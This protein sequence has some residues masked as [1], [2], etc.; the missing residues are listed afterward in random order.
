MTD[1]AIALRLMLLSLILYA[2]F[3]QG[4]G[5]NQGS[6]FA[7][8]HAVATRGSADIRFLDDTPLVDVDYV[9]VN[10]RMLA[11]QPPG[12]VLV[13]LGPYAAWIW[14]QR[15]LGLDVDSIETLRLNL[16]IM[17]I[18]LAGA[19]AAI[20][21]LTLFMTFR[22]LGVS[23]HDALGA[24]TA[25]AIGG[26]VF[27]YGSLLMSHALTAS[28]LFGGIA[29]SFSSSRVHHVLAGL[30]L[31]L[32]TS[33]DYVCGPAALMVCVWAGVRSG[34]LATPM[35]IAAGGAIA[36]IPLAVW[37]V[38]VFGSLFAA[39]PAVSPAVGYEEGLLLGMFHEPD[40]R[41]I[42]WLTLHPYRGLLWAM[43]LLVLAVIGAARRA[44]KVDRPTRILI[45]LVLVWFIGFYTVFRNWPGGANFGP[46]YLLP[47]APV[48]Y[49]L[50]V[51]AWVRM[52]V[53]RWMITGISTMVVFAASAVG[54]TFPGPTAGDAIDLNPTFEVLAMLT[55]GQIASPLWSTNLGMDLGLAGLASLVPSL[56]LIVLLLMDVRRNGLTDAPRHDPIQP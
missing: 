25:F 44:D 56:G 14:T 40:L 26:L 23:R 2:S 37:N 42:Y 5:A 1:R 39:G 33:C 3:F 45:A 47:V 8:L 48:L 50:A 55:R 32:A 10:G 36:A 24:A 11:A 53:W 19:P 29:L 17:S 27:P 30:S 35:R 28:A 34:S 52:P 6:R 54:T 49:L 31:G 16:R 51:E 12:P 20:L 43:P 22:R 4:V 21:N 15:V 38:T 7:T 41:R 46:R 18:L 9:E 13:G